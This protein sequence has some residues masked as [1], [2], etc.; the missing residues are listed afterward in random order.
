[1]TT[2]APKFEPQSLSHWERYSPH[3]YQ[4]DPAP[5]MFVRAE[6]HRVTVNTVCASVSSRYDLTPAVARLLAAELIAAAD[7]AEAVE[8]KEAA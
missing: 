8:A 3:L 5:S 1:M 7:A 4:V 6:R 2:E